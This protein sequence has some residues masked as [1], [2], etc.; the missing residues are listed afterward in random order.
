MLTSAESSLL[1]FKDSSISSHFL[2]I[3]SM[4][5]STGSIT[6]GN[7]LCL[8]LTKFVKLDERKSSNNDT[9]ILM[10]N[11]EKIRYWNLTY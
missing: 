1:L 2:V 3:D 7:F 6:S 5:S 10:I 11:S 4:E 9:G 8:K